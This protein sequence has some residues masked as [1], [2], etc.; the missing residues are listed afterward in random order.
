[1]K[2]DDDDLFERIIAFVGVAIIYILIA[3]FA[4]GYIF[5]IINGN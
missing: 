1:M 3:L 2:K 5:Y 4:V